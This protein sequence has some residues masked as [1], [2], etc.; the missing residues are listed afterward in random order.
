MMATE[1]AP[2]RRT[3]RQPTDRRSSADLKLRETIIRASTQADRWQEANQRQAHHIDR[4]VAE[5][6]TL[7]RALFEAGLPDP[8][9]D[10][11]ASSEPTQSR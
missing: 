2:G 6:A 3:W 10:A 1:A 5:N 4:L 9:I 8:T 7:R 11:Q